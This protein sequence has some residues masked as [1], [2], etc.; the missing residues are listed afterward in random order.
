MNTKI[1]NNVLSAFD[2]LFN[3]P[4]PVYKT[5]WEKWNMSRSEWTK[6]YNKSCDES[7][8]F[9]HE[10]ETGKFFDEEV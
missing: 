9:C 10:V 6:M 3:G 7:V 5:P 2:A 1:K 4:E 8:K